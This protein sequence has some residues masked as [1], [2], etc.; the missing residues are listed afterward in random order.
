MTVLSQGRI[1]LRAISSLRASATIAGIFTVALAGG[2]EPASY[3]SPAPEPSLATQ[4]EEP[5]MPQEMATAT[6]GGGCFWCTEA[7]FLRL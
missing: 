7:V 5:A 4:P 3:E 6:F 1:G 2:C